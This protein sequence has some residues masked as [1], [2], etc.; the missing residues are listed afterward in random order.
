MKPETHLKT[1]R[2]F[3]Q[4]TENTD[5]VINSRSKEVQS[6]AELND[7]EEERKSRKDKNATEEEMK[8]LVSKLEDLKGP[9]L[10]IPEYKDAYKAGLYSF[11]LYQFRYVLPNIS[12]FEI[13]TYHLYKSCYLIS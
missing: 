9:P 5:Y 1:G 11:V 10:G 3:F 8:M 2:D 4:S 6:M 13:S 12:A 7:I